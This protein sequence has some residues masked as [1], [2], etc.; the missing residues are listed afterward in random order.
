M[1]MRTKLMM[2]VAVGASIAVGGAALGAGNDGGS[3]TSDSAVST[4]TFVAAGDRGSERRGPPGWDQD[5]ADVMRKVHDAVAEKAPEI[6]GP[7]IDKAE[8]DKK[9]TSSQADKLREAAKSLGAG[10]PG[11]PRPDKLELDDEDVRAVVEDALE[12]V[13][14]RAPAIA[15]PILDEAVKEKQITSDEADQIRR[16]LRMLPQFGA[17]GL[18]FGHHFGH[19]KAID[20][21]VAEALREIHQRVAKQAAEIAGPVIDKA[22]SDGKIT[23]AQ[24]DKL[25]QAV[26]DLG[27]PPRLVL[28]PGGP[29]D[30]HPGGPPRRVFGPDGLDLG[31]ADVREVLDDALQ[32][33]A[34]RAPTI[35]EPV[36][37]RAVEQDKITS[38]QAERIRKMLAEGPALRPKHG[39]HLGPGPHLDGGP[40]EGPPKFGKQRH[41]IP[42][43]APAPA[44]SGQRSSTTGRERSVIRL[45]CR[46]GE[47]VNSIGGE[48][49]PRASK[50][51]ESRS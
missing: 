22:R 23:D 33:I 30:K 6:A 5:I 48:T 12:A 41:T 44:P 24:A 47:R 34:K 32:A 25:R 11:G 39:P 17:K 1:R 51:R 49:W 10:P 50:A 37:D 43:V 35:A 42:E 16:K 45:R 14:K 31:D 9:I 19:G 28:K 26:A 4:P 40:G 38:S 18:R 29:D 8:A 27:G 13:A 2:P 20:R 3:P 36:I 21:D 7:I 15:E 46:V